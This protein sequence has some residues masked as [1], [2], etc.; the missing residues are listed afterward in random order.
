TTAGRTADQ[1]NDQLIAAVQEFS[2]RSSFEDD[3]CVVA[4][5][6]TG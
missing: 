5:E 3:V 1:V 6:A 4:V 2:G